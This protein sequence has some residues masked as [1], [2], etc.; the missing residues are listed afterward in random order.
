MTP[1]PPLTKASTTLHLQPR[2]HP[3]FARLTL[4]TLHLTPSPDAN[5]A[6]LAHLDA[7]TIAFLAAH[8]AHIWPAL[9]STR[10][11]LTSGSTT[12]AGRRTGL[13]YGKA[14]VLVRWRLKAWRE[15]NGPR[16]PSEEERVLGSQLGRLVRAYLG[17]LVGL[18]SCV[19]FGEGEV[20]ERALLVGVIGEEGGRKVEEVEGEIEEE[21]LRKYPRK[22]LKR[23]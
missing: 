10:G 8:G 23:I 16:E 4:H 15:A 2:I 21:D 20:G 18:Q 9:R 3:A 1:P 19:E 22:R 5:F 17:V 7:T 6:S 11:H 12:T 14:G 13:C